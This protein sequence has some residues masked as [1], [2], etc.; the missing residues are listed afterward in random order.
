MG[1]QALEEAGADDT[2]LR[3][4]VLGRV[5][6]LV[7]QLDLERGLPS[8]TRRPPCSRATGDPVIRTCSPTCSCCGATPSWLR[9]SRRAD[10][11]ERGLRLITPTDGHGSTKARTAARSASLG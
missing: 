11:I 7:M 1:E 5:A 2:M 10:E 4:K 8:S 3:A 6:F 9:P